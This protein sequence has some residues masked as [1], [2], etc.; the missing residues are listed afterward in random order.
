MQEPTVVPA[1]SP[2]TAT[3][4][5]RPLGAN[6]IDTRPLPVG[7]PISLQFATFAVAPARASLAAPGSNG[8][9]AALLAGFSPSDFSG[10]SE[11]VSFSDP[12]GFSPAEGFSAG[13]SFVDPPVPVLGG[14]AAA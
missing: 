1:R 6:V 4:V 7:P 2:V 9:P 3:D 5:G 12:E 8:P 11:A 14:R 13:G 10:F